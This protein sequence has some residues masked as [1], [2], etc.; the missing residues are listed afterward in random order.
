MEVHHHPKMEHKTKRVKEYFLEFLMIFLAVSMGFFAEQLRE[1][2]IEREREHQF[3]SSLVTD[4]NDD[5]KALEIAIQF[6]K[7]GIGRL[8]SLFY[9]LNDPDLARKNG[10]ELYYLAR[11]GPRMGP[12]VNNNRTFEQ[13]KN[14]GGFR[15]ITNTTC[16][17]KIMEYYGSFPLIRLL[18]ENYN[19]EFLDFRRI[20]SKILDPGLL[21]RQEMAD[22]EIA[23]SS[24][25]PQLRSYDIELLKEMG[26]YT[27]H[28]NG[29]RR[30]IL[31]RLE[32]LKKDAEE[33]IEYLEKHYELEKS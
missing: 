18:E 22:G 6:Q 9:L 8:D 28:L 19:N 5:V 15:L 16:S 12:F 17:N 29:T 7:V 13:L 11:I 26:F 21:R 4:L 30:G 10:D 3:I 14:S 24:D 31:P 1:R 23:R 25:N 27:V 2:Q 20:S 33:L 32:N